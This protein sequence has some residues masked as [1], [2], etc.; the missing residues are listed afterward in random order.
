MVYKIQQVF[1]EFLMVMLPC[2]EKIIYFSDGCAAQYI[3]RKN[4]YN[5]CQHKKEF[6]IE[7][8]WNFFATS[9]GK[10][11]CDAIGGTV[12]RV[13][14]RA[15][16]QRPRGN[17]ILTLLEMFEFCSTTTSLSSIKFFFISQ[18][19]L[20]ELR[21]TFEARYVVCRI[22]SQLMELMLHALHSIKYS[23]RFLDIK[24][25]PGTRSC[26][27]FIPLNTTLIGAKRYSEQVDFTM[28]FDFSKQRKNINYN[29]TD[30]NVVSYLKIGDY[31]AC[32][33]D[34]DWYI[35]TVEIVCEEEGDLQIRFLHPKGPG[36]PMNCF[37]W[38]PKEDI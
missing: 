29:I 7:A 32:I 22:I 18:Y 16:L 9:Y 26:H 28:T 36:R 24:E 4:L 14:A 33:Y 37:F 8:D 11:P 6:G 21:R 15:S 2:I 25:L 30:H 12:K 20:S 34:H 17:Q 10:S 13:T 23:L 3:N 19:Q 27:Q 31:V 5:L 38:P 35:G 1:T